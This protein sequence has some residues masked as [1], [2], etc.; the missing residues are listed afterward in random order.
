MED[1]CSFLSWEGEGSTKN[2]FLAK[3]EGSTLYNMF[4]K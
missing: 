2:N 3:L 1:F 4:I